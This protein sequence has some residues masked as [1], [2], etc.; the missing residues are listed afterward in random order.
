[1][2]HCDS[3]PRTAQLSLPTSWAAVL[4]NI[5]EAVAGQAPHNWLG[6]ATIV[7]AG[8]VNRALSGQVVA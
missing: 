2:S 4:D 7:F 6:F 5:G 8:Q 3:T 1:M